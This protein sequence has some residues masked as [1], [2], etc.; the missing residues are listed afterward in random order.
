MAMNNP[1]TSIVVLPRQIDSVKTN[2]P[3]QIPS[4]QFKAFLTTKSEIKLA[5]NSTGFEFS[6]ALALLWQS[7]D[8]VQENQ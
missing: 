3:S 8:M 4:K 6:E 5:S 2:Q 1:E 7:F